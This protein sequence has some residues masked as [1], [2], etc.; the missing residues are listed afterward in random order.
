MTALRTRRQRGQ[1]LVPVLFIVVILT[2][3]V[4]IVSITARRE[5]K[6]AGN[7]MRETQEHYI[8]RG[9]VQYA[10]SQ[11]QQETNGG[12]VYPQ[13]TQPPDT[14]SNGWTALGEGFYKVEL[15]DTASRLNVNTTDLTSLAAL[16]QL[17]NDPSLA[18]SIVDWRDTD[19]NPTTSASGSGVESEY[20]QG[21]TPPYS[22]RNGPFDTVD[23][24][25][26]VQGF[27]PQ[28][29]YGVGG[30]I[31]GEVQ[32]TNPNPL[33]TR[34][35]GTR[36]GTSAGQATQFQIPESTLPLSELLTVYSKEANFAADGTKRINVKTATAQQLIDLM[37][38][39]G[40]QRTQAQTVANR[41]TQAQSRQA[42]GGQQGGGQQGGG[43][44]GGGQ[45]GGGQQGGGQQGGGQQGGGQQGG[46]QQQQTQQSQV[47][48]LGDLLGKANAQNT[49]QT[50]T[51][52]PSEVLNLVADNLTV[53][54]EDFNTNVININTAPL[55]VLATISGMDQELYN[56]LQGIKEQGTQF[57]SVNDLFANNTFTRAQLQKLFG[58]VCTRSSVYLVRVKVR[59]RGSARNYVS[60]ALVELA[61]PQQQQ[62]EVAGTVTGAADSGAAAQASTVPKMLQWREVPRTP[63]WSSWIP[64][65]SYY[66]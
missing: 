47:T 65:R 3:Y 24:L 53:S 14:D 58:K 7:H 34:S 44:Q 17:A 51:P 6:A 18:P 13:L 26:L 60:Q 8:A 1:A 10:M 35:T 11:L 31:G 25:L 43:Q 57:N 66:Q 45:Q 28:I 37:V 55:E 49:G 59:M 9:A 33:T 21:L 4:A 20:Y 52:W 42:P 41:F 62:T 64:A 30:Q 56:V 39:A 22:A 15:V 12:V 38:A 46:G 54:D 61:P 19:E 63:G 50:I 36:Q 23:E 16:P 5:V 40:V 48:S 2:A 27:S 32:T 29:L